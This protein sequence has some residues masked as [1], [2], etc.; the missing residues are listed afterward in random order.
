MDHPPRDAAATPPLLAAHAARIAVDDVIAV[1]A[2]TCAARGDR[3]LCAG[4]TQALIAAL[5]GVPLQ[6][7]RGAAAEPDEREGDGDPPG[8][9][10]V[11]AG[12]LALAGRDVA[13]GAHRPVTGAAPLDP[14]LP[15]DWTA[16]AYVG[17]S[18]RLG[19]ASARAARDLAPA[20]LARAGLAAS[21]RRPLRALALPERRALVIAAAIS[22]SPAVVILEDPL[23][24]LEGASAAFVLSAIAGATQGRGAVVS[25]A[26]IDLGGPAGALAR[27][28]THVLALSG[29]EVAFDGPLAGLAAG[30]R[31]YALAVRANA[32]PLRDELAARG[33]TLRGGPVRFSA[34]L[35]PGAT[36]RDLLA[37]A[38]R[39]RA[40][41]VE[42]SPIA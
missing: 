9:A 6:V 32:G 25:M 13:R 12:T 33:I 39:A 27:E 28:A 35:P 17:W 8:E 24:G 18:A 38:A 40:P 23:S 29:G 14:P 1:E 10:R 22:L 4:D 20:A 11:V 42:L 5:T 31:V 2:L 41:L 19:G 26:R 34:A 30:S 3:V 36:A 16:D 7:G 37:A 15:P 21:S